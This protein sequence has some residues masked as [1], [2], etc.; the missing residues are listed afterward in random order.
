[1]EPPDGAGRVTFTSQGDTIVGW[2]FPA[3]W[4][5]GPAP[6][7]VIIGPETYQKE[8]APAQYAPRFAQLGYTA[9]IFD[10]RYRGESGGEPRCYEV[11]HAKLADV[12]AAFDYLSG[13]ADIDSERLALMGICFGG[14]YALRAAADNSRIR[15]VVTVGRASPRHGRRPP[16]ARQ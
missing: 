9:L 5:D 1:M 14:S 3:A 13:R 11:P 2:L 10:P 6:G 8:Q 4:G 12:A 7:V 16:L 15:A